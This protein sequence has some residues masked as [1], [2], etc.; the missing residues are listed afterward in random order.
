MNTEKIRRA[1]PREYSVLTEVEMDGK[2]FW[3]YSKQQSDLWKT[4]L[5]ITS[6]SFSE[7]E[8]FALV[9]E[10]KIIGYYAYLKL[11]DGHLKIDH[12]FLSRN[13]L[14]KGFGQLLLNDFLKR[15]QESNAFDIIAEADSNA[16]N[17]YK[18]F[19]FVTYERKES[20]IKGSF[21]PPTKLDFN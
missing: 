16:E 14:G 4:E 11:S 1:L 10:G 7:N 18:K 8:T 2:S 15:A 12:L 6:T 21:S 17:F 5:P 20:S 9:L 3:D 13:C 19:G